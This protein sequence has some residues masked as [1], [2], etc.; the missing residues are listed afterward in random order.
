VKLNSIRIQAINRKL[1]EL[2]SAVSH[3]NSPKASVM[4]EVSI[5]PSK[6]CE[7]IKPELK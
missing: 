2:G 7:I 1:I 5:P 4:A 3:L 6:K